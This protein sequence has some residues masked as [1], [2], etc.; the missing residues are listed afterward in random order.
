M[1]YIRPTV[2]LKRDN[3]VT[4][5]KRLP[6]SICVCW[7]VCVC[8]CILTQK[9]IKQQTYNAFLADSSFELALTEKNITKSLYYSN[10][11]YCIRKF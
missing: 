10:F 1:I 3:Q 6:N 9:S 7:S 11:N 5:I 8:Q 2:R 4:I